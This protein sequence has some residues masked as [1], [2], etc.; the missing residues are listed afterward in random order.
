MLQTETESTIGFGVHRKAS[1]VC[2]VLEARV[3]SMHGP[4]VVV[5]VVVTSSCSGVVVV[6]VVVACFG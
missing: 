2:L 5:V 3:S 6:V 1:W 4:S